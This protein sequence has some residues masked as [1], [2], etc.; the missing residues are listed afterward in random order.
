[1]CLQTA[2]PR[3]P[4]RTQSCHQRPRPG[5]R[6]L[7]SLVQQ[8]F[9]AHCVSEILL[10]VAIL[11]A[12]C[13]S[14]YARPLLLPSGPPGTVGSAT[15][16]H[17]VA[18]QRLSSLDISAIMSSSSQRTRRWCTHKLSHTR[19]LHRPPENSTC[20]FRHPRGSLEPFPSQHARPRGN[21]CLDENVVHSCPSFP[22]SGVAQ[23]ASSFFVG[24]TQRRIH[25]GVCTRGSLLAAAC[26]SH[27]RT[28]PPHEYTT[29]CLS[30]LS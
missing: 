29:I 28:L 25:V 5:K 2:R 16:G 23:C 24:V 14:P 27:V 18:S 26:C 4:Q 9:Q 12:Q 3:T 19:T 20:R 13:L 17:R 6:G 22:R 11:K 30:V 21:R 7:F 15:P 1:M 8:D 10:L